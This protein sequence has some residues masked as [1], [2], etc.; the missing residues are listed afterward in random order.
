MND[1]DELLARVLG[2]S[3]ETLRRLKA[4]AEIGKY[5]D[6]SMPIPPPFSGSGPVRLVILGQDPTVNLQ[7][8][9]RKVGAVLNLDRAGNLRVFGERICAELGLKLTEH[10]YAT[11]ICKNFWT[12]RPTTVSAVDLLAKSWPYWSPVLQEELA[13]LPGATIISLGQPI[14]RVLIRA[15]H[16]H[17]MKSFWG[18]DGRWRSGRVRPF[19]MVQ[20]SEST[21]QRA[22]FPVIHQPS[23]QQ[24][25]YAGRFKDYMAFI[26]EHMEQEAAA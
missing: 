12:S 9:R 18:Y 7:E 23:L 15:E 24:P 14:L 26:R 6:D 2:G 8:S 3:E 5:V 1:I 22:F 11:N 13:A 16:Y 4:D 10:V 20:A 19:G 17:D 21:I 25:F